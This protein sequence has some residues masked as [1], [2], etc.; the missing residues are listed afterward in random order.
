MYKETFHNDR[1]QGFY[2]VYNN[3]QY[4]T[5]IRLAAK[6][7]YNMFTSPAPNV[8]NIYYKMGIN[9]EEVDSQTE[10]IQCNK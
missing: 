5:H 3:R 2:K 10:P 8:K 9:T 6:G 1:W 7:L 4:F